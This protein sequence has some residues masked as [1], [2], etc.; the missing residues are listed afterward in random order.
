MPDTDEIIIKFAY[1]S[2]NYADIKKRKGNKGKGKF[3]FVL[4]LDAAGTVEK[5]YPG[6]RFSI[7][8]RVIAFPTSGSY[9]EYGAANES[10][11]YRIPTASHLSRRQPCLR[12][13]L[14]VYV[15]T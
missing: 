4:G 10:L 6:S 12:Y 15:V 14:I 3:P 11:V 2:V 7:G 1:T 9:A 5:V 8:E 13:H